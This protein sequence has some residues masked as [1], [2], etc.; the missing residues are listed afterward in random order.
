M[1]SRL[2]CNYTVVRFLPYVESG[3]FVN[4]GVVLNCP[5][6][7]F[8]DFRIERKK[9]RRI[10]NFF[11]ELK[12]EEFRRAIT[13]FAQEMERVRDQIGM[14]SGA[15]KQL[16]LNRELSQRLFA[17]VAR[18]RESVLRCST[19]R[20]ALAEDPKVL[21]DSLFERYVERL[22]A[23]EKDF[24]EEVMRQRLADTLRDWQILRFYKQTVQ[25]GS[26]EY[27]VRFPFV[28]ETASG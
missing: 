23:F 19:P 4:I 12:P 20:T 9:F 28:H 24:Q 14:H 18:P 8:F 5:R 1:I 2:A 13:C 16:L 26:E 3:E 10:S 25:V 17:E 15:E 22:F 27:S 21:L 11:P 7:G 6:L